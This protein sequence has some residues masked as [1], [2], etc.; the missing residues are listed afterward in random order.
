MGRPL[1]LAELPQHRCLALPA[2]L[3]LLLLLWAGAA[4]AQM[5]R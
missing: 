4:R 3:L 2:L 1:A 5:E